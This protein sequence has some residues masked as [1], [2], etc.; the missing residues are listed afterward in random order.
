MRAATI[1]ILGLL[2]LLPPAPGACQESP[3]TPPFTDVVEVQVV[4]VDVHVTDKK[5]EPIVGL[6]ADDFVLLIDG[7]PQPISNFYE[8]T[9]GIRRTAEAP[10]PSAGKSDAE[11]AAGFPEAVRE[12]SIRA[13]PVLVTVLLDNFQI[14]AA[15]RARV[16]DDL[17]EFVESVAG[18][19][20]RFLVASADPGLELRSL[21][22]A[23]L[24]TVR[25][26]LST[27]AEG[28]AYGD[29]P[30]RFWRSTIDAIQSAY[31][32][33]LQASFC[34]PCTTGWTEL[35]VPWDLYAR[36]ISGR[37]VQ[38][39]GAL[40]DLFQVLDGIEG[41]KL[42]LYVS[43]GM[44]QRPGLDLLQFLVDL[45]PVR[46][47]EFPTNSALHDNTKLLLD[48]GARASSSR[49]SIYSV[50]AAGL[51]ATIAGS[52]DFSGTRFRPS[53]LSD[54]L[55]REN[56]L[57][58]MQLLA[59][60]T[61]GQA[62][63]NDNAPARALVREA[64]R[65][66]GNYYSLGYAGERR[67]DGE[68]H[69][70]RV[71]V[72]DARRGW[73]IRSRSAWKDRT[74]DELLVDRLIAS[75][76]LGD[77]SNPLAIRTAIDAVEELEPGAVRLPV[78]IEVP[79]ERLTLVDDAAGNPPGRF[80]V[81]LAAL[82]ANG[83]RTVLREKFFDVTPEARSDGSLRLVVNIDLEPGDYT[84]GVGVRDEIG[85]EAS[86]LALEATARTAAQASD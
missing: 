15:D 75:M 18:D 7:R 19:G 29:E 43:G 1:L 26:A 16:L 44:E 83:D 17:E 62:I 53:N 86:Y 74:L 47:R 11:E 78:L 77:Q 40:E 72:V 27:A 9:N 66:L 58:S 20:V 85:G 25:I 68:N 35:L 33:C 22:T 48:L 32:T 5:G 41:R 24:D 61:G 42:L 36:S 45:C 23:D 67:P 63:L 80:R 30:Y 6:T 69:R 84:V 60:R 37:Q 10:E 70:I 52:V 81:F 65:D 59:E 28:G 73:Q 79:L 4:N 46:E 55:R 82:A 76:A 50:H 38:S 57:G 71:E 39:A 56:V 51:Q 3:E 13:E 8:V 2:P 54:Q 64:G 31:D 21:P 34:Q 12:D 14:R 49:V